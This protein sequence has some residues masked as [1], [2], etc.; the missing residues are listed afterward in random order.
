MGLLAWDAH[1]YDRYALPHQRWGLETIQRLELVGTE[2][3]LDFGC[4]TGRDVERLLTAL[5]AG[6]VIAVD[7]SPEMLGLLRRRLADR[8]SLVEVI[9]ADL[10][11]RLPVTGV[12]AVM[13]VA[14]L[15]WLPD[16]AQVFA[17]IFEVLRPGGRFAA[18]AGG[19]GNIAAVLAAVRRA[20]RRMSGASGRA[21]AGRNF[22]GVNDTMTN[23]A[24]AGFVDI[25]VQLATESMPVPEGEFEEFLATVMLVPELTGLSVTDRTALVRA[26]AEEIGEPVVDWVRLRLTATRP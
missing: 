5:P 3:V 4:G 23:L 11:E 16:H 25:E 2:T 1:S 20:T 10:R 17:N 19:S 18:E 7:G 15:H 8:A 9:Q 12:D 13:S 6:R 22:M 24:A 21:D 14:T 26:V